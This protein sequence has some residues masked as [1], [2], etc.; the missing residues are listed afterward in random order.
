MELFVLGFILGA[1]LTFIIIVFTIREETKLNDSIRNLRERSEPEG[2]KMSNVHHSRRK[3]RGHKHDMKYGRR[4]VE[5]AG[6]SKR[7]RSQPER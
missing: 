1:V 3:R 4:P 6:R 5:T 2:K 7:E